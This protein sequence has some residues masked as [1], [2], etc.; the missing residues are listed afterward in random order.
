MRIHSRYRA[1]I[2]AGVGLGLVLALTLGTGQAGAAAAGPPATAAQQSSAAQQPNNGNSFQDLNGFLWFYNTYFHYKFS[3]IEKELPQLK[4]DGFRILGFFSPY[5]GDES[6]CDGCDP[7]NFFGVSP[8]NGTLRDW[9]NLIKAAHREGMKVVAYFVNIYMDANSPYFV[10]AQQEYAAGD[11][12]SPEVASFDWS[13]TPDA[14]LPTVQSGPPFESSWTYSSIAHAYYWKL[15]FGPGFDFDLPGN[16]AAV[17]RIEKFWLDTGIDGFMWDVGKQSP[18][19]QPFDVTLPKTY[20]TN[21][22]WLAGEMGDSSQAASHQSFGLTDWFNYTNDD[23]E[24]DYTRIVDGSI[25]AN[26]L[27]TALENTDWARAHGDT[28]HAWSIWGDDAATNLVPHTYPAYPDDEA[29]RV[30]E[31]ALLAG[32]GILYGSAMYDQYIHWSP[33]LRANW[34][35]V[36]QT[37]NA[38]KAL[39]PSASRTRV[40]AGSDPGVY[41]MQRTSTDGK[42]TALLI[43]NFNSTPGNVTVDLTGTGINT[44][45]VPKDL[46]KGGRGSAINGASYTVS[47]PAYGFTMLQVSTSRFPSSPLATSS[48]ATPAL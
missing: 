19:T 31:A 45:Q 33:T 22:K 43:Y 5:G 17:A 41:A 48:L 16:Q 20:T 9:D 14:P 32:A 11:R 24:N 42:Q 39:L 25:D 3:D 13:A 38:N 12:T 44:H 7:V 36:L 35:R 6:T 34:D 4:R 28:T 8:Q 10:K 2:S 26:G 18:L 21:D 15:W 40:P 46:Y 29:E 30:Q 37:V 1:L 27:E 23:T 47:L